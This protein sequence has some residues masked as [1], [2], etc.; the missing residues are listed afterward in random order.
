MTLPEAS[1]AWDWEHGP[2]GRL[3]KIA[4]TAVR[5]ELDKLARAE[6]LT[7][8]QWSALG[9]LLH[10]PG[11]TNSDLEAIL[12]VER[13]SVTSLIKGLERHGWVVRRDH[14]EDAR[15]K[16]FF[17]TERGRELAERTRTLAEEADRRILGS[18]ADRESRQLRRL[19]AK[20]VRASGVPLP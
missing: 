14:P 4:Y 20:V 19:L 13:P 18:L 9:V 6:G 17:L 10:F 15:S 7:S 5:R 12:L 1:V 8:A 2:T 3:L 11:A 16:Q